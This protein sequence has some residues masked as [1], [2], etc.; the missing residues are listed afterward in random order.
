MMFTPVLTTITVKHTMV[1]TEL[2]AAMYYTSR[3]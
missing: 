1:I 3:A 2:T